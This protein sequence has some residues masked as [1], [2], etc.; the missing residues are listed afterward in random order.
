MKE[1]IKEE[2]E[3]LDKQGDSAEPRQLT[4]QSIAKALWTI[5]ALL[6]EYNQ[7]QIR[8]IGTVPYGY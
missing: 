1:R 6:D 2:L 3:Q 8:P 4:Q 7:D 5:A